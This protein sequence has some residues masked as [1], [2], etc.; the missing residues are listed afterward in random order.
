MFSSSLLI[1][2]ALC[3]DTI[4]FNYSHVFKGIKKNGNIAENREIFS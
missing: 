2:T 3:D 4:I 1:A